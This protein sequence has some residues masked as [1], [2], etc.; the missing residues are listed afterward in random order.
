MD[1]EFEAKFY[2]VNKTRYR[3]KLKSVGAK[4]ITPER[5]MRR[6]IYD[7][8]DHPQLKCHYL[9]VRDEGDSVRLSAKTHASQ[10][11]SMADQKEVDVVVSDYAKTLEILDLAGFSPTHYTETCR[12]TW[13]YDRA[14]ITI[15]TLPDLDPYSEIEGQS[16]AHVKEV[17]E[18]L[19]FDWSKK[20]ISASP[21]LYAEVYRLPITQV[22]AKYRHLTFQSRPFAKLKKYRIINSQIA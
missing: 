9:R 5:L 17:A 15:D 16:E 19:G 14:E 8:H 21:E 20:M 22:L 10:G 2:P 3:Q 11:G 7:Y 6:T 4:L 12:E 18:K 1:T 13:H